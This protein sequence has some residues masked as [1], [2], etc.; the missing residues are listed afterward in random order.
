MS[1]NAGFR[2]QE[3]QRRQFQAAAAAA[4][5]RQAQA[6]QTTREFLADLS[7][8]V[9]G[10][11]QNTAAEEVARKLDVAELRGRLSSFQ[12]RSFWARLRWLLT[13]Q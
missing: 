4:L 3:I 2:P 9:D 5:D 12:A 8:R 11:E 13:G 1:S 6:I 10:C 7:A